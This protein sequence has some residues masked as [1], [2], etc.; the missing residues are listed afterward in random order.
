MQNLGKEG[1]KEEGSERIEQ[2][3]RSWESWAC[4]FHPPIRAEIGQNHSW[5]QRRTN[6]LTQLIHELYERRDYVNLCREL[7]LKT[8]KN[9]GLQKAQREVDMVFDYLQEE[10]GLPMEYK[11]EFEELLRWFCSLFGLLEFA[12]R[13]NCTSNEWNRE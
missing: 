2:E 1:E 7:G 11:K 8:V 13:F 10:D 12:C 6:Q 4:S 5:L 3:V 9:M